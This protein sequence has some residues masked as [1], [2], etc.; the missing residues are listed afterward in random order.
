VFTA[1][2]QDGAFRYR[3]LA[4][5]LPVRD[6]TIVVAA[7]L[8]D[9][10]STLGRLLWL[11]GLVG[12]VVLAAAAGL[13][14]W[15]VRLGF[16]PLVDIENTAADIAAGNLSRRVE[17]A[18]EHTEIG[19]LGRALNAMLE[20][21]EGAFR[22][23][24]ASE[25]RLRRFVADASHELRTPLT[26][27]RGYAELFRRGADVRPD[28][29]AKSMRRIEEEA[30]RMGTLV[31][32]LLLLARLDEGR[33]LERAPVDLSR[34][35]ADAVHDAR[36]TQPSRP[37]HLDAADPVVVGGDEARLRQV[38]AN[39]L[40]NALTH[41][42]ERTSVRVRVAR[43]G[44]YAAL[45]VADDGPGMD[46][47]HAARIFDRFFRADPARSREKGNVGLGLSIVSAIVGAHGGHVAV[48]TAPG[49]GST[50]LVTLPV[51]K[52]A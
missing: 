23:R 28:D 47:A 31:E 3:M 45:E 11:E 7:P 50:F 36:A 13:A 26:S 17:P 48:R 51:Q 12:A 2:A 6:G 14:L 10:E 37:I 38:A 25:E 30:E 44:D 15:L 24:G 27:I 4:T 5:A 1:D 16:K 39:L 35:A 40:S 43:N 34:I 41:T 20:K 33:P 19:R 21:I 46:E 52:T 29:L 18:D 8:Q 32:E 22:E 42:P 49:A 9:V